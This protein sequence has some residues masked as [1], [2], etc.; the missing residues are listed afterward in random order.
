MS[1]LECFDQKMI[2][3]V[4][5]VTLRSEKYGVIENAIWLRLMKPQIWKT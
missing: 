5:T 1:N 2:I 3:T 4:V